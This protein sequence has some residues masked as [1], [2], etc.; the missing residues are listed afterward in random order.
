[1]VLALA[2]SAATAEGRIPSQTLTQVIPAEL[3]YRG[4]TGR[5]RAV[6]DRFSYSEFVFIPR[7]DPSILP[8]FPV[9]GGYFTLVRC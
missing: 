8:D 1:L 7:P 5:A 9:G 2:R 6:L 3:I 4:D